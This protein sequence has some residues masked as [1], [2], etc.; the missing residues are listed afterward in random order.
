MR[1]NVKETKPMQTFLIISRDTLKREKYALKI[2]KDKGIY[3][4]DISVLEQEES[5]GIEEVRNLQKKIFLKP[6]KGD[7]KATIIKNAQNLT[8]PAQNALLKILEEPPLDTTIIVTAESKDILLPTIL[9]R[10][11]IIELKESPK[12][13][14]KEL[15]QYAITLTSLITLKVPERLKLAQDTAKNKEEALLWLKKTIFAAREQLIKS[16][17]ENQKNPASE[18]LNLLISLNKTHTILSTTNANPRL[19][20]ENLFLNL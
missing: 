17:R 19:T 2:C 8:I 7:I 1:Y 10:C 18:Y 12:F 5:I 15:T 9:S 13:S 3:K 14:E 4:F 16:V 6:L 11:K 20:L